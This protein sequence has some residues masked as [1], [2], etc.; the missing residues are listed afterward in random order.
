[1]PTNLR[2]IIATS[3]YRQRFERAGKRARLLSGPKSDESRGTTFVFHDDGTFEI[4]DEPSSPSVPADGP[5]S[6][7][8]TGR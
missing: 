4:A 7:W 6:A 5:S 8:A 3:H 1:M 2:D